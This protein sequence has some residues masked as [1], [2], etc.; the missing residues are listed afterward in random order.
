MIQKYTDSYGESEYRIEQLNE[1]RRDKFELIL[2]DVM[3]KLGIEMWIHVSRRGARDPMSVDLGFDHGVLIVSLK[4][5]VYEKALFGYAVANNISDPN[6][7]TYMSRGYADGKLHELDVLGEAEE[8]SRYIAE[9]DP[10][11][12]AANFSEQ[13]TII[14]S[15]SVNDM[16]KLRGILGDKYCSRLISSQDLIGD[17]RA[18]RV[19]GEIVLMGRLCEIQ[20]RILEKILKTIEPNVTTLRQIAVTS[21]KELIEWGLEPND[22]QF[23]GAT[24]EQSGAHGCV[25]RDA[26]YSDLQDVRVNEGDIIFGDWGTE[27]VNLN[28]GTDIKRS[29]YI[30][31]KGEKDAPDD[32]KTLW[33]RGLS[34]RAMAKKEMR[35]GRT[36]KEILR[37]I[38]SKA[39]GIGFVHMPIT[40][41]SD[42][43]MEE[44]RH[45]EK[46]K[47][48]FAVDCHTI[49]NVG[50][51]CEFGT[52]IAPQRPYRSDE[53]A[54]ENQFSVLEFFITGYVPS[55]ERWQIVRFED[56]VCLTPDGAQFMYPTGDDLIVV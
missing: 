30:L 55:L 38:V 54:R 50:T 12:I 52:P 25:I 42:D 56:D 26:M 5:D 9:R 2:P 18:R 4:N 40:I 22:F 15:L 35:S 13:M 23:I 53:P 44:I 6:M 16:Q 29:A 48:C 8:M 32:L 28:Y 1:I 33:N 7:F 3:K 51:D 36:G 47:V 46:D 27:R 17:F 37:A 45:M 10:K 39:E 24:L 41:S 19:A 11:V 21:H 31:R 34:F 14:D 43:R 49:G 20:R